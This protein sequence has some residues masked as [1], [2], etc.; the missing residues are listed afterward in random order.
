MSDKFNG[1]TEDLLSLLQRIEDDESNNDKEDINVDSIDDIFSNEDTES[2][3]SED[4]KTNDN[5]EDNKTKERSL[6]PVSLSP[7]EVTLAE[8]GTG[9]LDEDIKEWY[10]GEMKLPSQDIL[11]Y[12]TGYQDKVDVGTKRAILSNFDMIGN[13]RSYI[14]DL[15]GLVFD[16]ADILNLDPEEQEEKLKLAFTMY[17]DIFG[18][19]QKVTHAM[20]EQRQKYHTTDDTLDRLSVLLSSIPNDKLEKLLKALNDN[21]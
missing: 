16:R 6:E 2:T 17:K 21:D 20:N 4:T 9:N 13:L 10:S 12:L 5:K 14:M 1:D 19:T 11:N 3:D 15:M 18:I 7:D 8:K